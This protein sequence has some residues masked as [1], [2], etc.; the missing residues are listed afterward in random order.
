M[1][2]NPFLMKI[3]LKKE[4]CGSHAVH[5]THR[6]THSNE[7]FAEKRGLWV[8]WIVHRPTNRLILQSWTFN[9]CYCSRRSHGL[10]MPDANVEGKCCVQTLTKPSFGYQ[11]KMKIISLFSLF[12]CYLSVTLHFLVL[13]IGFIILF[14]L[15][16]IFIYSIF[17]NK[18]LVLVK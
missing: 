18:F 9:G 16:F 3:L 10:Q 4:V 5:G 2:W 11:W 15:T 14:Q 17:S 8:L 6:G 7:N 12:F 1:L 13:F